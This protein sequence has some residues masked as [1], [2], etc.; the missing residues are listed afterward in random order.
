MTKSIGMIE[1]TSIAKGI[2]V[3][4]NV[5]KAAKTEL[6]FAKPSC[7]GKFIVLITGDVDAVKTSIEAGIDIGKSFVVDS[8]V[9]P[10]IHDDLIPA[11]N[12]SME[13]ADVNSLGVME[14]FSISAAIMAADKA[15]KS[16][17]VHLMEIRLGVGVGGKSYVILSGN[18]SSVEAAV[19]AGL[20]D[21]AADGNVVSS[22]IIPA[23]SRDLFDKL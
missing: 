8:F 3:A 11:I 5:L 13:A 19:K 17:D 21:A 7:P 12:A 2:Q 22:C 1:L 20:E 14:F 23:P 16:A 4:D 10:N 15:V 6:V 9:I 18:V